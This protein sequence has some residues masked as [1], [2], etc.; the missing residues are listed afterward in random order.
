MCK[1]TTLNTGNQVKNLF[2][3]PVPIKGKK[4]KADFDA[5]DLSSNGGLALIDHN[6][7]GFVDEIAACIPDYRNQSLILH[8]HRDMLRQRVGQILCGY[9]DA[10]DC[11]FLREDSALKMM[12]DR[13]PSDYDLC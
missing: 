9:E 12:A 4:V 8:S 13:L 7:C 2:S 3:L 5:P 10:S 11:D 1:D 6:S